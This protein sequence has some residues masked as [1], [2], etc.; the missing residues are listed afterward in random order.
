MGTFTVPIEVG[1]PEGSYFERIDALVDTG[2]FYTMLPSSD[3]QRLGVSPNED[4]EFELADGSIRVFNLGET[5]VRI[6]DREVT[7][8]VVFGEEDTMPLLGAY[9]LERLRLAVDPS[10]ERLMRVRPHL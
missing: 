1:D 5:R 4:E 2:A 3:L 7:T 6:D 9:T 8:V 10:N